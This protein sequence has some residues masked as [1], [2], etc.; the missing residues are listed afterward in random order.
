MKR[1]S[2]LLMVC[3]F[4]TTMSMAQ[5]TEEFKPGG[6][7]FM[8]IFSNYNTTVVDGESVSAFEIRRVY[9]G[10]DYAFSKNLTMKA[11]FD[12]GDPGVGKFELAAYVKNAYVSYNTGKLTMNFGMIPTTQLKLVEDYWGYRYLYRSFQDAYKMY[13]TA[14]MGISFAY[15][16]NDFVTA[17]VIVTNGEG[18][19]VMQADS[20]L[21]TGF[22][23]TALPVKNLTARV[24]YDFSSKSV[25]QSTL[26]TFVGFTNDHFSVGAEYNQQFN[27]GFNDDQDLYGTSFY[28]TVNA[29]K[30]V[31]FFGR[32]DHLSSN[33]LAGETAK[34]NLSK[35]GELFIAGV[36]FAPL[37]GVKVAPNFQ[38][39]SP[40]SSTQD[41]TSTFIVNCEFKF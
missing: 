35:N 36:E 18:Y 29:S 12:I 30:K 3:V 16:L 31:K 27:H 33:K 2:V 24:L 5:T 22:G 37:K 34:W 32:Y 15:A 38:G 20:A 8:K 17:D 41:F 26:A 13:E 9:L 19:K 7:P 25:T 23:V 39:W 28:A 40:V 4:M 14:D 1:I 10:Y 6:K 21:R 11:N